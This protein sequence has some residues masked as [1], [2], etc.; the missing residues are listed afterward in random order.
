MKK[1][2]SGWCNLACL[3]ALW[4]ALCGAAFCQAETQTSCSVESRNQ[5]YKD[6]VA[7][8]EGVNRDQAKAFEAAE[9]YL[10]CPLDAND[11]EETLANLNLAV[12]RILS[13]RD[14][15][16]EA[17]DYFIKAASYNS[18][19]KTSP[20]T[21]ADLGDA[22]LNGPYAKKSLDYRRG[23]EGRNETTDSLLALED[24][25]QVVDRMI[26]A[27]GRAIMLS[28]ADFSKLTTEYWQSRGGVQSD[29]PGP[30]EWF[31]TVTIFYQ[32]RHKGTDAGLKEFLAG[33]LTQP[34]PPKPIPITSLPPKK[35]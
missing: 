1:K 10:S 33:I 21:Y 30:S 12:G 20:Q 4:L 8:Y 25:L 18:P 17:I 5:S 13:S 9:K 19:V 27:Y 32:F 26:D 16:K 7:S 24:I 15:S 11:S 2:R 6:F 22:Y 31:H 28:N 23:F 29:P 35:K 14:R 34:L 3:V